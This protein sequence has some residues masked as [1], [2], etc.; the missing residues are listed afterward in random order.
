MVGFSLGTSLEESHLGVERGDAEL[1]SA[2]EQLVSLRQ[3]CFAAER[4]A[5]EVE[6]RDEHVVP[7]NA[8]H[9]TSTTES[10]SS[11]RS[12]SIELSTLPTRPLIRSQKL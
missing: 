10:L 4:E 7:L 6:P 9:L 12:A 2:N 5:A 8:A 3:R 1:A 11:P